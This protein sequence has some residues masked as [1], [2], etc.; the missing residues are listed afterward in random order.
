VA[1]ALVLLVA[2]GALCDR[3]LR[4]Y[5][6]EA[7]Y[8]PGLVPG[9]ELPAYYRQAD[10]ERGFELLERRAGAHD[11]VILGIQGLYAVRLHLGLTPIVHPTPEEREARSLRLDDTLGPL[12]QRGRGVDYY[13]ATEL[14]VA[15]LPATLFQAWSRIRE[16]F[17][18][19]PPE[20][21]FT[22]R[23][24][25]EIPLTSV[26]ELF[27]PHVP[28]DRGIHLE[29]NGILFSMESDVLERAGPRLRGSAP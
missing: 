26:F 6:A 5:D 4:F 24:A 21:I 22:F 12:H 7:V 19:P 23:G 1:G 3:S 9:R 10:V 2:A 11:V 25:W 14:G 8:A 20:R 18:P 28:V 15:P 29:S 27:N 13:Y 17:A 16:V